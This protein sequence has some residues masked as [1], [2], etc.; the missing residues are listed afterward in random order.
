M[1]LNNATQIA[2]SLAPSEIYK[3]F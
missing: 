3:E 2:F 1:N